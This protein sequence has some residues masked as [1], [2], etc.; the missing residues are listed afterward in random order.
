M[1][2]ICCES[3]WF[4]ISELTAKIGNQ[5]RRKTIGENKKLKCNKVV[6]IILWPKQFEQTMLGFGILWY[7]FSKTTLIVSKQAI[8]W[9]ISIEYSPT[10]IERV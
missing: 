9:K 1:W 10:N 6:W 7:E 3:Y 8:A 4:G 5:K 2:E